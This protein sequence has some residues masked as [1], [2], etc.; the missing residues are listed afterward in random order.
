MQSDP[1]PPSTDAVA[2]LV[3]GLAAALTEARGS[4]DDAEALRVLTDRIE[5]LNTGPLAALV[6]NP[7]AAELAAGHRPA[8][9]A[10]AAQISGLEGALAPRVQLFKAFGGFLREGAGRI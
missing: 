8:L 7:E 5:A 9:Q 10:L 2:D 3:A 6:G 1:T 4:L